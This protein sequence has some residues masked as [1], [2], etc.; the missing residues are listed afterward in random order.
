M[1]NAARVECVCPAGE[2]SVDGVC[3]L[4]AESCGHLCDKAT[5]ECN[6]G[7]VAVEI[8][9]VLGEGAELSPLEVLKNELHKIMDSVGYYSNVVAVTV[10]GDFVSIQLQ[11]STE[12]WDIIQNEDTG[13][14][15]MGADKRCVLFCRGKL[16]STSLV[17]L[18]TGGSTG[19]QAVQ[20]TAVLF[21]TAMSLL[22]RGV[23]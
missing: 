18:Y 14:V 17:R 9:V 23:F 8:T 11:T 7:S 21:A 19:R 3:T 4:C 10:D 12:T 1:P 2:H 15:L 5:G 22:W 16:A 6:G 20:L 13:V